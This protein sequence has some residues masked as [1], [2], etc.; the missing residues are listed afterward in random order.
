M[1]V[2]KEFS[3][4]HYWKGL[5][6][7]ALRDVYLPAE[8]S[9]LLA[10][11]AA[12]MAHGRVLEIGCGSG[13]VSISC[14][15][16]PGVKNVTCTDISPSAVR[17]TRENA[18]KSKVKLEVREGD[19]FSALQKK[20]GK[21]DTILFNPPYLPTDAD[22]KVNGRLNMALDGGTEGIGVAARFIRGA[23]GFLAPGGHILMVAST[24]QN[25]E[26]LGAISKKCGFEMQIVAR[27]DLFF[28]QLQIWMLERA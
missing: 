14:A 20:C 10:E 21:F 26:K 7:T 8:D 19:L 3:E 27:H 23:A 9:E 22:E 5:E 4:T 18:A 2:E 17:C 15:A 25:L 12:K 28:E 13:I 6:L 1:F 16:L 24:A 11:A